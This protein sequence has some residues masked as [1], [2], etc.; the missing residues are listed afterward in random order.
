MRTSR[1]VEAPGAVICALLLVEPSSAAYRHRTLVIGHSTPFPSRALRPSSGSA[2]LP[3]HGHPDRRA[4]EP[5]LR[6]AGVEGDPQ[7]GSDLGHSPPVDVVLDQDGA[8]WGGRVASASPTRA[9][10]S[11]DSSA[12]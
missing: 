12:S 8:L 11:S 6:V 10:A 4:R 1:N 7:I 9:R 5:E 3:L 2:P